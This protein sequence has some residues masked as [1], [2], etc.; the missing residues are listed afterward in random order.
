MSVS[1]QEPIIKREA[2][3][4]ANKYR[5]F[6]IDTGLCDGLPVTQAPD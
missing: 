1:E 2:N 5:E 6:R 4:K 3:D